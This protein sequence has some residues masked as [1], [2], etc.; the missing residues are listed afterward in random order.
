MTDTAPTTELVRDIH[1]V[2]ILLCATDG[3]RLD[4]NDILS[5]AWSADAAMVAI[6]VQRLDPGFFRLSTRIAGEMLQKFV[7]YQMRIAI[8]GDVSMWTTQSEALRDFVY[9]TNRGRSAWFVNDIDELER[10]LAHQ[11]T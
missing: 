7:N 5:A 11:T 6:P 1:G 9:E 4:A 3:P 2:R 10:R 8:V